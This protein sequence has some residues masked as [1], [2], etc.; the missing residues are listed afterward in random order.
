M[1]API[2]LITPVKCYV[3]EMLHSKLRAKTNF[4]YI[5]CMKSAQTL[6]LDCSNNDAFSYRIET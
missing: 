5:F 4:H 3:Q 1:K 2:F 6:D